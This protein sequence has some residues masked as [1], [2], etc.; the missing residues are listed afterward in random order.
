MSF[1]ERPRESS[2][3]LAPRTTMPPPELFERAA[4]ASVGA[5][6]LEQLR[7]EAP[8]PRHDGPRATEAQLHARLAEARAAGDE[9]TEREVAVTLA[10]LLASRGR[11]LGLATRLAQRALAIAGDPQL[12]VELA[13]WLAGL[14]DTAAAAEVLRGL[15][16]VGRDTEAA[17][18]RVKIAVLEARA[19]NAAAA[20]EALDEAASL[21]PTEAMAV[22]LFGTLSAWA[23]ET[24]TPEGAAAAYLEAARRR[25]AAGDP[26]AAYEDRLRAFEVAP[27]DAA[28]AEAVAAALVARGL[29]GA[30]DEVMRLAAG[31]DGATATAA[32]R[33]RMLAALKDGDAP[34]ALGAMLDAALEGEIEGDDAARVDE[35]LAL[36]GLYEL[37]AARLEVRAERLEGAARGETYQ[38]LARLCVG[39]LASP[40]RAVEAWIEALASEPGSTAA[41]TAL[42][43][44]AAAHHDPAPL[45]EALIRA[46]AALQVAERAGALRELATLADDK[47]ADPGLATWALEALAATGH[48]GDLVTA[49]R[50]GLLS[51]LQRQDDELAAAKRAYEGAGSADE[52]APPPE[53]RVKALRRMIA[54]YQGRPREIG[55]YLATLTE[56]ARAVP[57]E[58][59]TLL[60]LERA[61]HRA[62]DFGALEAVLRDRL[63]GGA[64][65]VEVVRA[66][67]GLAAIARRR[68]DEG[69]A[70]EEVLPVLVEAPGHRGAACAALL[71][72]TRAGRARERADALVQ[73][74]GPA[75][76]PLRSM[77]LAVAAELYQREGH[78]EQAR[79]AAEQACEADPGS[80]RALS[81]LSA[82]TEATPDRVAAAAVERAITAVLPRGAWCERLALAFDALGEPAVAFAWTQR[83]L[84]LHP[85]SATAMVQLLRRAALAEGAGAGDGARVGDALGWVLAQPRPL[86]DLA[87]AIAGAL[88]A[89]LDLDRVRAR[90]LARRALD[91]VGPRVPALRVR[92]LE[93]SERAADPGLAIA[94]LERHLA[95]DTLGAGVGEVLLDLS[96]RRTAAC[97]YDGAARELSRAAQAG[98]DPD[99]VLGHAGDL[100]AAMREAGAWLGSDGRVAITEAKAEALAALGGKSAGAAAV[101]FREL[102]SLRWDL[103]DDPRSAEA[104]FFR[105]C[106]LTPA[107]GVE[108]YSRD[109]SAFGGMLEAIDALFARAATVTGATDG[110]GRRLRANLLI[111]AAN[112]STEQGMP[113]RAL[114]AAASAIE[115]DP[116]RA[117]AVPL[118][119]KNAHVEGGIAVLDRTYDLLAA[120]ALGCFGRRSAHYRAARQLEKRGAIDLALRHAGACFEAVPSEGTSYVLLTRLAERAGDPTEAVRAVERVADASAPGLRPLWLKRAAALAGGGVEGARTRFDLLL[121]ALI[122]RPDPGTVAEVA[123][124]ARDLAAADSDAEAGDMVRPRIERAV[125]ASL[126]RLNGP[127]GARAAVSMT[128]LAIELGAEALAFAALDRAME[129]DGSIDEFDALEALIPELT[130]GKAGAQAWLARVRATADKP[131]SSVGKAL[132]RLASRVA[133]G[134]GD[135]GARAALLVTAVRR[136]SDDDALV[137]E[138][139][140]AVA[141]HGDPDLAQKLD[142][143]VPAEARAH[144]QLRLAEEREREGRDSEAIAVLTRARG[145]L[146]LDGDARDRAAAQL[147]RLLGR[148]GRD[149]DAELFLRTEVERGSLPPPAHR[150]VAHDLA[151]LL[152]RRDDRRGAFTVLASLA[153]EGG[154]PDA[155]LLAEMRGLARATDDL[156]RYAG[157]LTAAAKRAESDAAR[158][159]I[160]REIAPLHAELG[161]VEQAT[162]CYEEIARLDPA[163]AQAIELLERAANERG[164]HQAIAA[165][166]GRRIALSPAGDKKRMLRLRR[167]AVLEQRLGLLDAAANELEALLVEA[168]DDVS[169]MRFLADIH[170]RRGAPLAAGALLARLEAT[171]TTSDEKAEYGLRTA[172]AYLAGGQPELAERALEIVAPFAPRD[173]LLELRVELARATGD[174]RVLAESLEQLATS[175]SEPAER[176]AGFLLEAARAASACGEDAAALDRAR[177]ALKLAPLLPDAV[178]EARRLEYRSGGAGTPREAQAAVDELVRIEPRLLPAQIELHAFLLAEELDVIQGGGA[179]M[180]ELSRRHAEVGPLPLIALGMAERMVRGKNFDA[181][182]PLFEQALAGDLQG[183]RNR[184]RVALAAAEAAANEQAFTT[185]A[186]LLDV[187]AAEPETQLIAQRRQLELAATIGDPGIARQALEELLRQAT[188]LD[189]ARVLLHLGQLVADEDPERAARFF[190]EAAPLSGADRALPAQIAGAAARLEERRQ[191]S[192]ADEAPS[193]PESQAA[194]KSE[195]PPLATPAPVTPPPLPV[196]QPPPLPVVEPTLLEDVPEPPPTAPLTP[197]LLPVPQPPPLPIVE[198]LTPVTAPVEVAP[199]EPTSAPSLSVDEDEPPASPAPGE[200]DEQR[201]LHELGNG[202][203]EAGEQ[204]VAL[205][206]ARPGERAPDVLAVRRQ[207]AALQLGDRAALQKL[208]EAAVLDGNP[209]YARSVEHVLHTFHGG[210]AG[211]AQA[212]PLAT[213]RLAPDLVASL[214]F[215]SIAD[216]AVHEALALVLDTGLYRRDVGQYQLTGVARVQPTGGSVLGEV[217]GVV[218]RFLGQ[219]RTVLFYQRAAAGGPAPAAPSFKIALL[220]PPAIVMSGDVREETPE[221][222][223]LLGAALAGAMPEHA[224][225]NA[226]GEEALRTLVDALHAAFGPVAHLP[227]GNAAV[228]RLGQNLWQLVPPRADRRL[229]ELCAD[230]PAITYEAAVSGTRQAMRRA[231]LF[232]A[233]SLGTALTLIA[234]EIELSLEELQGAPDGLARACAA[235]PDVADLVRLA[236]RTELAEARWT[237]GTAQDRRRAEMGPRSQRWDGK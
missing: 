174:A 175:S 119:E 7:A 57:T 67:L 73:L 104:A 79:R 19:G 136:D 58:R 45:A 160:L 106:E 13:G 139:D 12:R 131:Y 168:P 50:I 162:A 166:I 180:R 204:L 141:D 108:R 91:V 115:S 116:S 173:A 43:D 55:A 195:E 30:A 29:T 111:E 109:M 100:E 38:A 165:L 234:P 183:M 232:A 167:A 213:Q 21:D 209:T 219:A 62:G 178:L 186:K 231:G 28:A 8:M 37:L 129:A 148:S 2:P 48:E 205:Y 211:G 176:R 126:R 61:A 221:L 155:E 191:E 22:E 137:M 40:D 35:A 41:R 193:E 44:H 197:P 143:A 75:P 97:D 11:D 10:R 215:R 210:D 228:A 52:G 51:R 1:P 201:L 82:V 110:E 36:A 9:T 187:A 98:G 102:G 16:P 237:P 77:L 133:R 158:L 217:F 145:S 31:H 135:T 120:A 5:L 202:S 42:R 226:L 140:L 88:E 94:V 128:R 4:P 179:G 18:T 92:L 149:E 154:P 47:M 54:V 151:D 220:S 134:L 114:E 85:G 169:A 194:P 170:E 113:E 66:R 15:V 224:L 39:P 81:T 163:D 236:I 156:G 33:R 223:Y 192:Q 70:L 71:F 216:S 89:L 118:V 230:L 142:A 27:H 225:V 93:L 182:L 6:V 117:D 112:L 212:P 125:K 69:R 83:W 208:V 177:R 60:A 23:P 157:V 188:G 123:A 76:P 153:S 150:R 99:R 198:L 101:A 124:A 203:F 152:L 172:A 96:R 26:E 72:A 159:E 200:T 130:A 218:A 17:R 59:A 161:E 14:G 64:P 184:G 24:V 53:A 65:R 103:A 34:R 171:A 107:G 63:H 90:T 147:Q 80:A 3:G 196:L 78:A 227:R 144:A 87:E 32:H 190:A 74:A 138:A 185:A 146:L 121:R 20:A 214:L 127:D 189:R 25:E 49:D 132:L 222:R 229:R 233:G 206:G 199:P 181:A 95:T 105:A 235:H 207:Q 84:A 164:D 86:G 68:G 122:A 56:L 46:G